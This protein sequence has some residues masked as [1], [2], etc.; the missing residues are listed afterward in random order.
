MPGRAVRGVTRHAG[1]AKQRED[2]DVVPFERHGEGNRVEFVDHRLRLERHER[3][4]ARHQL[5]E[6]LLGR[7]EHALAHHVLLVVEQAVH[8]LEPQVGHPDPVGVREGERNAQ[9]GA[10]RLEDVAGFF[11]KGDACAFA[12]LPEAHCRTSIRRPASSGP[13]RCAR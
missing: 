11:G 10:V 8:R 2:V 6:L 7:Q 9:P 3:R 13:G 4:L 12:L 1:Q 5:G